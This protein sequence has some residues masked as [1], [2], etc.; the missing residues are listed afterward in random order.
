M[1]FLGKAMTGCLLAGTVLVLGACGSSSSSSS[2]SS[3]GGGGST[4]DIY[5]SLPLQGAV[6]AQTD[7]LVNGI[8]LAL[9]Q[10]GGKA[11]SF[12]VN[13]TSL[14]DSTATSAATTCDV[15]QSAANARK[16]AT[17]SK[18]VYYIGEF[19]SGCSKV[20]IPILNQ[21]GLP[22]VSPANTY[23]GLTTN[24]TGSAPGEPQKYYPTGKR[25][26]LR[27]VPRDS[28]QSIAGLIAMKQA[29]CTRVAVTNDKTAYGA[30]LAA[31]VQLHASAY[32]L[33]VTSNT[34]LDPTSPNFRSFATTVKGQGATCVYT[35]FNPTGEVELIKDITAAIPTAKIYGG[36]G[37]CNENLTNPAKGGIPAKIAPLFHCTVATLDLTAYPGGKAFLAQY[38]AKYG[39]SNP[40]PYAI[41]GYEA[42][43]LGLDTVA[44]LGSKGNDKAAVL[45]ALFAIKARHS[46]LGTYGFDANGDTTLK[47][48]GLYVI[49]PDGNLKFAK[50][51]G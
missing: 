36:D 22:Q 40:D 2:S 1:R 45:A 14:D 23:V 15:N 30:G 26:F 12:T 39:V 49:G 50:T 11:G 10:A 28:I 27:L 20:T 42:M 7:P 47:K 41:Y 19:N 44:G 16:A 32:G 43:K 25:T 35:G 9:S 3:S 4:I 21:A 18:A 34:A 6:T 17:D 13:Y 51:V 8:K 33:K 46:V 37:I 48:Y 5:S 29:G 31:Q 24:D 38:K